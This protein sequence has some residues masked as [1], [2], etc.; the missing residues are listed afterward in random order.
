MEEAKVLGLS[1]L[2][3]AAPAQPG[4]FSNDFKENQK[5]P[6]RLF[7]I[8]SGSD[9]GKRGMEPSCHL[10]LLLPGQELPPPGSACSARGADAHGHSSEVGTELDQICLFIDATACLAKR[11][12]QWAAVG[13][14]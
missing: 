14:A 13:D 11:R 6:G 8:S 7:F 5:G 4:K 10:E 1:F 9:C 12:T 2:A 3:P